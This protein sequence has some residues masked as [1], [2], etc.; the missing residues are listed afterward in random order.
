MV[1]S[2]S[3]SHRPRILVRTRS[4]EANKVSAITALALPRPR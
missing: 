4:Q 2:K 1:V 3:S